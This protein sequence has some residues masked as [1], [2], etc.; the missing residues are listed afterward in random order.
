[1]VGLQAPFVCMDLMQKSVLGDAPR[2]DPVLGTARKGL[3]GMEFHH[4]M[5]KIAQQH[6]ILC[7]FPVITRNFRGETRVYLVVNNPKNEQ[8][9]CLGIGELIKKA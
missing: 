8:V 4:G 5:T 1:M 7:P 3:S 9:H 6:R 2:T